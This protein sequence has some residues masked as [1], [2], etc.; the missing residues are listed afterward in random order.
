MNYLIL[1]LFISMQQSFIFLFFFLLFLETKPPVSQKRA[2]ETLKKV[3]TSSSWHCRH[4][5][6]D[7]RACQAQLAAPAG[8]PL[9]PASQVR[10]VFQAHSETATVTVIYEILS[11]WARKIFQKGLLDVKNIAGIKF[12]TGKKREYFGE[13]NN[14]KNVSLFKHLTG[15]PFQ[16]FI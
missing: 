1:W 7:M 3:S 11:E 12:V 4:C 8:W 6:F 14:C 15:T 16:H 13:F 2:K 10:V 5:G 9:V